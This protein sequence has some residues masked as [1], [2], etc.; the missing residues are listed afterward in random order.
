MGQV[1]PVCL[2]RGIFCRQ[3]G[4]HHPQ[5]K[6]LQP[7]PPVGRPCAVSYR[8]LAGRAPAPSLCRERSLL[9]HLHGGDVRHPSYRL[10]QIHNE[11]I[12]P[13]RVERNRPAQGACSGEIRRPATE[14]CVGCRFYLSQP[15][16]Q[17]GPWRVHVLRQ[18]RLPSRIQHPRQEHHAATGRGDRVP[19][20]QV[21]PRR[22]L[23]GI[24]PTIRPPIVPWRRTT[25][26]RRWSI[27]Q[28]C[29]KRRFP[30]HRYAAW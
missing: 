24:F 21:S 2:P 15:R 18:Q 1:Y 28:Q 29:T 4:L 6:R 22:G 11:A 20:A 5:G 26:M 19:P 3:G 10:W 17:Q 8:G 12:F 25:P 13:R 9:P 16:R 23:S 30:T 27:L 14:T 7:P